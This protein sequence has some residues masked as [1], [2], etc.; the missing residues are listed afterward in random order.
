MADKDSEKA[1]VKSAANADRIA[2]FSARDILAITGATCTVGSVSDYHSSISTDTRSLKNG[3]WYLALKGE[4]FDGGSF[5]RDA[6]AKGAAGCIVGADLLAPEQDVTDQ[7]TSAGCVG[8]ELP[9]VLENDAI[10]DGKPAVTEFYF[11]VRDTLT[12]Y[13]DLARNWLERVNPLVVAITGSS[14]KT[15]TKEMCSAI[16]SHCRRTHKSLANENN[17][18]GLP[19]TILAMPDGTE[20]L[21]L[22]MAMRGSGQ[23]KSLARTAKP[24][25]GIITCAGTAHIELLGSEE[26]IARAKCELLAQMGA[27]GVAII[28]NPS[29]HLMGCVGAVFGGQTHSF[30]SDLIKQLNVTDQETTFKINGRSES[31]SVQAHGIY[32]LQDAWCAIMAGLEAGLTAQEIAAGLRTY[33]S[34]EGR[35]NR[36]LTT[37]GA[38]IVDESYNANPES[39]RCAVEAVLDDRVFP[40]KEKIVVLGELAELGQESPRLHRE[41]GEWLKNM[42]IAKLYT[43][44]DKA[45]AIAKGA[46]GASFTIIESPDQQTVTAALQQELNSDCCVMIKGSHC[47]NLDRL[48]AALVCHLD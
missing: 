22:E 15:T 19:K 28:G 31:F 10:G 41:L 38:V 11:C 9:P 16:F 13:H 27:V 26:N 24:D 36:L 18:F 21:I 34:I 5:V 37:C 6:I 35:G 4:R 25:I 3:E 48:V 17:E 39:V 14:G 42:P 7:Q 47:A 2:E 30:D 44:G 12:A 1:K 45:A 40:Q 46:Q 20:V 33:R 23:I 43:V 8:R 29:A 32:H